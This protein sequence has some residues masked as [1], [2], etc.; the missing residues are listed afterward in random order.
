MISDC[1]ENTFSCVWNIELTDDLVAGDKKISIL[2]D[3]NTD[4]I[5]DQ[6]SILSAFS[7][8]FTISE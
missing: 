2:Q 8:P 5:I 4:D 3:L 6:D 1:T 7:Q